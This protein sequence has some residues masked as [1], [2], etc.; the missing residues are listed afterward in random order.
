MS[1]EN[2]NN[3][4]NPQ[5]TMAQQ[6]NIENN[7]G[8]GKSYSVPNVVAKKFNWGAFIL[9]WIWGLGNSTYITF[10]IFAAAMVSWIPILG[11]AISLGLCIWFGIKGN[12][13]AW[14]NK[15]FESVDAFH[16]YQ[17]KWAVAG[18]IFY[19]LLIPLSIIGMIAMFTL[20]VLMTDTALEQNY[21]SRLKNSNTLKQVIL[22]NEALE[23]KCELSSDGL[24]ICFEKQMNGDRDGNIIIAKDGSMWT[25]EGNN[26]C[27]NSGDC[28]VTIEVTN[29]SK[30]DKA[31]I[32]LYVNENGYVQVNDDDLNEY[33][34]KEK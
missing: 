24:A 11:W 13:W 28:K 4:V 29:G 20:P 8:K 7:S 14:Q 15:H 33:T 5:S 23:E 9:T 26:I 34:K 19:C 16:H 2:Q 30:T 31:E 25:F 17:K 18:I 22:M 27:K 21:L 6:S 12:E 1:F 3:Q 32:P 10:L